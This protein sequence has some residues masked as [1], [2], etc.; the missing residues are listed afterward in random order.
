MFRKEPTCLEVF[1]LDVEKKKQRI[2]VSQQKK[3]T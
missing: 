3:I 1:K 2:S